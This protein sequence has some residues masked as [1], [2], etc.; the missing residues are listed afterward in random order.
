MYVRKN[1]LMK[2]NSIMHLKANHPC[3]HCDSTFKHKIELIRHKEK[4][5]EMINN[6]KKQMNM[7][8]LQKPIQNFK[9]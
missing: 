8:N 7:Q 2:H 4:Y 9:K 1:A 3:N 5:H 6:D